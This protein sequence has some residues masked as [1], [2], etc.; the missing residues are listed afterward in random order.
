MESSNPISV[1]ILILTPILVSLVLAIPSIDIRLMAPLGT[2]VLFSSPFVAGLNTICLRASARE[3]LAV[4][5]TVPIVVGEVLG[6][7]TEYL[8]LGSFLNA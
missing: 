2:V 1:F 5:S 4:E 7:D 3:C 6:P 8:G